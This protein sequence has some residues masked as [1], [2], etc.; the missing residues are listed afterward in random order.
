MSFIPEEALKGKEGIQL[1]PMVDFLFLILMFCACMA[2]ARTTSK[3]TN[4]DLVAVREEISTSMPSDADVKIINISINAA[5]EYKWITEIKDNPMQSPEEIAEELKSQ[6][7]KGLLS[8]DKAKTQVL[9]KIDR[10][11]KWEPILK[12]IF[13]IRDAGFEV[14]PVYEPA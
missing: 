11:S 10:E 13:A 4:I 6:Y 8:K 12:V 3:D 7:E 14:R 5:G 1:A 9:L 2:M